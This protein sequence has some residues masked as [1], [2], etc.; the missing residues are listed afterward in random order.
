MKAKYEDLG[1]SITVSKYEEN[2]EV[3]EG[4]IIEQSVAEGE[5]LTTNTMEVVVS[6]GVKKVQML[7]VVG[8]DYTVAKYEL[9]S[10]GLVPEFEFVENEEVEKNLIVSQAI[11]KDEEIPVGTKIKIEVSKGDGKVY[12]I[13]P[14]VIGNTEAKA[15]TA[16]EGKKLKVVVTYANDMS[17][18]DGIV[19][20]QSVKENA[21]VE[22]GTAVELSV[23]RLEKTKTVTIS[24]T[25]LTEGLT[26]ESVIVKVTAQVEG[27]TNTIHNQ[28]HTKKEEAFED[29]TVDVNGFTSAKITIYINGEQKDQKTISF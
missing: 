13:V 15:K 27:V 7:E 9:E 12:V 21:E 18:A 11:K 8:K 24:L 19:L 26:E 29:F 5:T 28:T 22:E 2:A 14:S 6:K 23:N 16:L 3:E 1:L 10:I 17:K 4:Y 20:T 25:T